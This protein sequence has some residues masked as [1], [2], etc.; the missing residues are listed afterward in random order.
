MGVRVWN[1]T[2]E[3]IKGDMDALGTHHSDFPKGEVPD[4]TAVRFFPYKVKNNYQ[5]AVGLDSGQILV[6]AYV[7]SQSA[8][9]KM[10]EIPSHLAHF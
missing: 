1:G 2:K 3:G 6:W 9:V 4:T 8:W 5:L 10:V 7:A